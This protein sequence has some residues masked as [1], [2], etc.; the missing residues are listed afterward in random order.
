M[1]QISKKKSCAPALHS[2]G[3]LRLSCPCAAVHSNYDTGVYS[4]PAHLTHVTLS[5]WCRTNAVCLISLS[6][7][8]LIVL[9]L[10]V[11]VEMKFT[12]W[13][14]K[15]SM[16]TS[17]YTA[18]V[19]IPSFFAVRITRHAISPLC[20]PSWIH[21]TSHGMRT[22]LFAIRILSKWG[23]LV[24]DDTSDR[25]KPTDVSTACQTRRKTNRNN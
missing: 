14:G 24:V 12:I 2:D 6:A 18:T 5:R 23:L 17:L 16:S 4:L 15:E 22:Y 20:F 7:A 21:F 9:M 10:R 8:M 1:R 25:A 19:L 3:K 13:T 11:Y